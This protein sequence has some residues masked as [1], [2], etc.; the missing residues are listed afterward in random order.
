MDFSTFPGCS[1]VHTHCIRIDF[2]T[3][4][5]CLSAHTLHQHRFLYFSWVPV[6]PCTT[7][8]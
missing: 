1:Y 8:A 3:F 5:G 4:P 6:C 2:S 7:S